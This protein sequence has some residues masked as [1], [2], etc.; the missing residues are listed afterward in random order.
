MTN[1]CV[2]SKE[3]LLQYIGTK[4]TASEKSSLKRGKF[5]INTAEKPEELTK[6]DYDALSFNEQ[7][8]WD[9]DMKEWSEAKGNLVK[10]LSAVYSVIWGQM[11]TTRLQNRLKTDPD[12]E[13]IEEK[14]YAS[15]SYDTTLEYRACTSILCAIIKKPTLYE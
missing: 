15:V 10:N 5:I 7:R 13:K 12:F 4:Y 3:K 11:K 6:Q 1:K 8:E 2:T 9:Q 14:H